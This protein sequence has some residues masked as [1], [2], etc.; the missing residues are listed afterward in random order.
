MPVCDTDQ[1][2]IG[3]LIL[4]GKVFFYLTFLVIGTYPHPI[5]WSLNIPMS[6]PTTEQ[7]Q[8][9][10]QDLVAQILFFP[11]IDFSKINKPENYF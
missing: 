5:F 9:M 1:L 10:V 7:M 2:E 6:L 8:Q 4:K 3:K 11:N